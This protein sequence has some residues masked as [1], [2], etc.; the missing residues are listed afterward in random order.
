MNDFF[1]SDNKYEIK[2]FQVDKTFYEFK[3]FHTSTQIIQHIV[4]E[5]RRKIND[6]ENIGIPLPIRI[7][8]NVRYTTYVYN[9]EQ[10]D[11]Y[12]ASF[13]PSELVA[14]HNF[15]IQ[16]L[17]L[18]LFAEV[19]NQIFLFIGGTG[20]RAILRFINHRFGLELYE[21]LSDPNEDIINFIVTRGISGN[22]SEQ[23]TTF[24]YGQKLSDTLNFT[25]I[26]TCI[27][28][29][30]RQDLKDTLFDFLE[31]TTEK[32]NLEVAS[33]FCIKIRV[34]FQELHQVFKIISEVLETDAHHSLTSFIHIKDKHI[35]GNDF[36]MELY[37]R[38]RKDMFDRLVPTSAVNPPKFDIDFV[39]PSRLQEFYQCD[40]YELYARGAQN[41]FITLTDKSKIYIE[42]LKWLFN[43]HAGLDF[44]YALSGIKVKGF[45][46]S[47]EKTIAMF[48]MHLTC[49]I[50]INSR[51]IFLID[52]NWYKVENN[53][54][55]TINNTCISILSKNYLRENI[56]TVNWSSSLTETNY[57][58]EYA[59]LPNF[60]N[61]DTIVNQGVE[62]CD[63]FFEDESSIYFIHVKDGFD[64]K[65][66][67]LTNQV[68]LSATRFWNDKASGGY[69]FVNGIIDGYNAK[70][71]NITR[72]IIRDEFLNSLNTKDIYFVI[73]FK[74]KIAP[75][76]DIR[77]DIATLRSNIAKY[78]LIQCVRDMNTNSYPIK[79]YDIANI[80]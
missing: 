28:L 77:N 68:V 47:I 5:H 46:G 71:E 4:D 73:A 30:L 41:P 79:I 72:Q 14:E 67:D 60:K 2:I 75:N 62:L 24:T 17:S 32:I 22:L 54:I 44:N 9:E 52:N 39:H 12:W 11:S 53:F 58:R 26:P 6:E 16:Q 61:F 48:T 63:I 19:G 57:N 49:E 76:L 29:I 3:D 25:N 10:K 27:N 45:R 38:I 43:N 37:Y 18:V 56:L 70:S 15:T 55:E 74:S 36:R 8:D 13:L 50:S 21:Y 31:L 65:I 64:G 20:I 1:D 78:S 23:K 34:T 51:P 59:S 33:Y 7:H 69:E 40:K 66:R 35:I 42:G 80:N